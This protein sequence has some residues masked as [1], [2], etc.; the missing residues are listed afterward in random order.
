MDVFGDYYTGED[1]RRLNQCRVFLRVSCLSEISTTDGSKISVEAWHGIPSENRWNEYEWPRRQT[2]LSHEWWDLWRRALQRFFCTPERKLRKDL[3]Y[4]C[5]HPKQWRWYYSKQEDAIYHKEGCVWQGYSRWAMSRV[6]R[7]QLKPQYQRRAKR[8]SPPTDIQPVTILTR[9]SSM[10]VRMDG[11]PLPEVGLDCSAITDPRI[12]APDLVHDWEMTNGNIEDIASAI[13]NGTCLVVS[14]GS[15]KEGRCTAAFTLRCLESQAQMVGVNALPGPL[16]LSDSFR[17]ELSGIVGALE[18]VRWLMATR[19]KVSGSIILS[20]DGESAIRKANDSQNRLRPN[21]A[22]FDLLQKIREQLK[23]LSVEVDWKWVKGH[24]TGK[25]RS[26]ESQLNT[27]CDDTAKEYWAHMQKCN[28]WKTSASFNEGWQVWL[29]S[30]KLTSISVEGIY[31][32]TILFDPELSPQQY[33]E[34]KHQ[35]PHEVFHDVDWDA[36]G[37]ANRSQHPERQRWLAKFLS[38]FLGTNQREHFRGAID[39][40][41]CPRCGAAVEDG[42]H[43]LQCHGHDAKSIWEA[44]MTNLTTTMTALET[45]P[46]IQEVMTFNLRSWFYGRTLANVSTRSKSLRKVILGQHRI[47]WNNLMYGRAH[48]LWIREQ[49]KYYERIGSSRSP[50]RWLTAIL[51]CLWTTAWDMWQHR[52]HVKFKLENTHSSPKIVYLRTRI[53]KLALSA[54]PDWT[55]NDKKMLNFTQAQ[56]A[57]W[58]ESELCARIASIEA[59]RRRVRL[60]VRKTQHQAKQMREF[61]SSWLNTGSGLARK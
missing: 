13:E 50:K 17:G 24:Q 58:T 20:L 46:A 57:Q 49:M 43:V 29:G 56:L 59:I 27:L 16:E 33:W 9:T 53:E 5:K 35:I 45:M 28:G 47:G 31:D 32:W 48:Y 25:N 18:V 42:R 34:E 15:F 10:L 41:S 39:N 36:V 23:T 26:V 19:N 3:G 2:S 21:Q 44:G 6:T 55:D 61:M 7:R 51:K 38:G 37:R 4:P 1:L 60:R 22:S 40:P 11:K 30:D 8:D 54:N 12:L 14:D 52:N